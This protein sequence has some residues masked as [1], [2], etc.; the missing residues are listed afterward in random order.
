MKNLHL[1]P[2][3]LCFI[4]AG[5]ASVPKL[6][7]K[8]KFEKAYIKARKHCTH[9]NSYRGAPKIK[10]LEQFLD[11][12]AAVQARDH[13]RTTEIRRRSGSEKWASLYEL[14]ADLYERSLDL[15][16]IAPGT[17]ELE[18]H[19]E[20]LPATLEAQRE[21]ARKKAGD[22]YLALIDP[23]LPPALA[24]EKPAAREAWSLHQ[25]VAYFLPERNPEFR[26]LRADLLDIG[27]LRILLYAGRGEFDHELT[28]GLGHFKRFDRA[29]TTILTRETGERIDL[30]AE[31]VFTQYS[32]N[33]PT[34]TCSTTQY[35]KEVLDWVERKKVKERINDSTVVEKIVVIEHF[36]TVYA[37]VTE[38]DQEAGACAFGEVRTYLPGNEQPEWVKPLSSWETWSNTYRYSEGDA[39]ALPAF[40]N[41]GAFQY[42]PSLHQLLSRAVAGFPYLAHNQLIREYTPRKSLF[43]NLARRE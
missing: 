6:L 18:R 1:L 25:E 41:D 5:C 20:L 35:E 21:E 33:L 4:F 40:P 17:A 29:W 37:S 19:P 13:A 3:L 34:E 32:E 30:E 24:G 14:Y 39:R 23:L 2:L 38:C 7:E 12:Y 9:P 42:P 43:G 16:T 27:T 36:K 15:V 26:A 28:Q 31:V 10:H 22:H 11:A 8:G